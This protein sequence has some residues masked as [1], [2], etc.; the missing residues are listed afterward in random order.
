MKPLCFIETPFAQ[1]FGIPRQALLA[2][3]AWG[4][5]S[6]PRTDFFNEAFR[7]I[8]SSTHLW[9]IFEFHQV[10]D[11]P[12]KALVRPPRLGGKEKLGVFATRSPHRPN[13]L[14]LSVVE[15]DRLEVLAEEIILWVKGVDV[16]SGTPIFDIKPYVPYAD[17]LPGARSTLFTHPPQLQMVRWQCEFAGAERSLIEQ[18]IALDPRP[19]HQ[20]ES[21]EEYG[22]SLA[23]FNVRFKMM[24][25]ALVILQ[26]SKE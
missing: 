15:F 7:G 10:L 16:V 6:F 8:E 13:H 2:Q 23:G 3:S 1:K 9:L 18:V 12:V 19:A 25:E 11:E 26:V 22:M 14:G 20:K 17:A 24:D 4:K 21:S 5:M